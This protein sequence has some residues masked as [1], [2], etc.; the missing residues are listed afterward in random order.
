MKLAFILEAAEILFAYHFV[1][2]RA[3]LCVRFFCR[4]NKS[5]RS[6]GLKVIS[7]S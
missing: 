4:R 3:E 6:S 2:L 7:Q 1:T 5:G